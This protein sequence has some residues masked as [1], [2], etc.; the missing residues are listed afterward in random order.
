MATTL[1]PAD[2]L[3]TA[4]DLLCLGRLPEGTNA[5]G[6]LC[7]A[8]LDGGAPFTT[9]AEARRWLASVGPR[10]SAATG[11]DAKEVLTTAWRLALGAVRGAA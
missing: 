2:L 3:A 5:L 7:T 8:A 1:H 11:H 10:A 6:A 4:H 9:H